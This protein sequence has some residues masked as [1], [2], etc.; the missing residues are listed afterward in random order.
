MTHQ[1]ND[2]ESVL[3]DLFD[4]DI[5]RPGE[6]GSVATLKPASVEDVSA[7]VRICAE[8]TIA[9]VPRG[10]N[11][12][13]CRMTEP[14][15][16]V[17]FVFVDLAM[18]NRI[19]EVNPAA[20]T[21]TVEAGCILQDVQEAARAQNRIF[22]PDWGAR[23]TAMVGGAVATN[24]GGLNVVRYG[25]TR[26][27]VLGIEAVLPDGRIWNGLRSL[28]K[29][30]SGYDLK[31]LLIGSEG[32]LGIITKMVMRLHPL[33]RHSNSMLAVLTD[34]VHLS[35]LLNLAQSV[36]GDRLAAFELMN[37]IG[38]EK[39]LERYP[40]LT[41]PL[42]TKS[43]WY[44]LIRL[45]GPNPVDDS[46]AS[47]FE[48]GFEHGYVAD[49]VMAQNSKQED[50][51]WEIRDQ[52]IPIQY[53]PDRRHCKWDVSVPIDAIVPFL[54]AAQSICARHQRSAIPYAVGHVG[55]GNIHY[56]IFPAEDPDEDMDALCDTY[57]KEIDALIW[58]MGGSVSAEHGVGAAFID[59]IR[60]QKSDVEYDL[61]QAVKLAL[62]PKGIMNP[63]KLLAGA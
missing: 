5:L 63:Q 40:A 29:D 8:N 22:A 7:I 17:D 46:L 39:A 34:Q 58:S 41:W 15:A 44:V 28:R 51:L 18:M 13:V 19:L 27:Q 37:G 50:N 54:S 49:A 45:A 42:D 48:A 53:F 12:N 20:N 26:E 52:M 35:D 23:G 9:I 25:T 4:P 61:M 2:P 30:N 1:I 11:S 6:D 10:G 55:D 38:V 36:A 24:G 16:G 14:P 3:V 60:S 47:V 56:S 62:D 32:T 21:I 59:R 31:H 33:P 57:L 43:D